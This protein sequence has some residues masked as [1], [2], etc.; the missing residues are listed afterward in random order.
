[1]VKKPSKNKGTARKVNFLIVEDNRPVLIGANGWT[2]EVIKF[3][4]FSFISSLY[5]GLFW[6]LIVGF[7][8]VPVWNVAV[9]TFRD[10]FKLN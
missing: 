10:L 9:A 3:I 4:I 2:P 1:M 8:L 6:G 5:L 7:F